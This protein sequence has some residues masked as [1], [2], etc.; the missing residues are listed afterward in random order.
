MPELPEVETVCR[1]LE[2]MISGKMIV[3]VQVYLPKIVQCSSLDT[4]CQAVTG[5]VFQNI[6]RRG[7]YILLNF[8][9]DRAA[10][11]QTLLVHL[12]MTGKLLY[13]PA[14]EPVG[15]HTHLVLTLENGYTLRYDDVRQ[16]GGVA[17]HPHDS[18]AALPEL[19]KLGPE[20]LGDDFTVQWLQKKMSGKKQKAKA[21]LLDQCNI[22]GIG[23][24]YADEI[25]FQA[26]IH[27]E[28][29]VCNLADDET[30]ALLWYAIRDRLTLGI[31]YG[32]SSIKDYVD[33]LGNAGTFQQMHKAYGRSG[34]PC[35]EC[36]CLMEK[37]VSAG[38]SSCYCPN[39]QPRR[40]NKNHSK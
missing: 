31:Q 19:T 12:R 35:I 5:G 20:P 3:D 17:L 2:P 10:S 15:K 30:V 27:P 25:L 9:S 26:R 38:R 8:K 32:G 33:S 40:E 37:M 11:L 34:K 4:F 39:C 18:C 24:I 21:F 28:E 36:G 6:E 7:K 22:A 16:F 23:N 29:P 1:S 14:E 13:L